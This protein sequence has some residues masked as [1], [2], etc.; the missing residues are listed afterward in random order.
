MGACEVF[1]VTTIERI[2]I[3]AAIALLTHLAAYIFGWHRGYDASETVWVAEKKALIARAEV[4]AAQLRAEGS[5]L[6]AELEIARANVRVEYV[7]VI[8]DVQKV[9][10][11]TRRAIG[12]DLAGMLNS[13]SGIRETTERIGADGT[14]EARREVAS[15]PGRSGTS[16]RALAEWIVGAVKAHEECRVQAN[17]L[18]EYAKACSR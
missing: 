18:I 13:L 16:E 9:A 6:A 5:R 11:A 17:A 4:Q 14:V 1:P 10:S 2:F 8:R 15:D 3:G 7:E 12:A